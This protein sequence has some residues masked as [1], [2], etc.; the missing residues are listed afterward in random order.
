MTFRSREINVEFQIAPDKEGDAFGDSFTYSGLRCEA[1]IN[2]IAGASLN[3]LQLRVY[4]MSS[5]VMNRLSTL[6]MKITA[7]RRNLV[8]LSAS[9][10]SGGMTQVFQGTISDAWIDY[11]GAPEISFNVQAL[12]GFYEQVKAIAVNSY[13]GATDVATVIESLAKSMGFSFTNNGVTAQLASPYFAGSAVTQI[14]DC[15]QH[16]KIA[17][18][19][20]N[21]SVQIWP[22]GESRDSVSFQVAPGSGLV[23]YPIFSNTGINIQTE[24]NQDILIGRRIDVQSSIP[25]ACG[26]WYCQVARHEIASQVPNGPWFTYAKLAGDGVHVITGAA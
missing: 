20:S 15:A 1:S 25:Q 5:V 4:G 21:G 6:G 8:T 22:S 3:S 18:D 12:A 16:A 26:T 24:F 9:N 7:T 14:K 11:R 17:Y 2:N 13:K 10:P 23:G 19:I